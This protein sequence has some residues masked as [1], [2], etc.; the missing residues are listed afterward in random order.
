MD[1]TAE[2]GRARHDGKVDV[3]EHEGEE[4]ETEGGAG[5]GQ[6]EG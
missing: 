4:G 1:G 6:S 2:G 5:S 3:T